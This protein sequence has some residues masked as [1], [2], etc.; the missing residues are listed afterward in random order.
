MHPK[1]NK[2]YTRKRQNFLNKT[3]GTRL[4]ETVRGLRYLGLMFMELLQGSILK[5]L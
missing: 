2:W 3:N 4:G 5:L 1:E